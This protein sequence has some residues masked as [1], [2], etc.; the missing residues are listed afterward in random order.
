MKGR[1]K[2]RLLD[3]FDPEDGSYLRRLGVRRSG[4]GLAKQKRNIVSSATKQANRR[5]RGGGDKN[6]GRAQDRLLVDEISQHTVGII[7]HSL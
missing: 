1:N 7:Q 6:C 4:I 3:S 5:R 2:D